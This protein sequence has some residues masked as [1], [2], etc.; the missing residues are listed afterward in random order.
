MP[1]E[2]PKGIIYEQGYRRYEGAYRGRGY[3][4]WSLWFADFKRALGIGK[5]WQYKTILGI[6]FAITFAITLFF[7]FM[8][9]IVGL[10]TSTPS[11]LTNP[12]SALFDGMSLILLI[13][14]AMVAPDLLC[15]DRKFKVLSLYLVR[16]IE[17]YDYLLAKAGAI[18]GVLLLA[19][20]VPQLGILLAKAFTARDAVQY[21]S[22]H[23]RDL[24]ALF[25]SSLIYAVFY[26]SFAMA[27]SSLTP[28]RAHAT[29]AI[30]TVPIVLGF[31]ALFLIASTK[32]SYWQLLDLDSLPSGLKNALFGVSYFAQDAR[33]TI[34]EQAVPLEPLA[35]W[36]YLVAL[37]AV[38]AFSLS[39]VL[40]SYA[41]ERP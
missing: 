36:I 16:P 18:F 1:S 31:I 22:E 25:V 15:S 2:V 35:W 34:N 40:F 11:A 8:D 9:F 23:T 14:S 10:G 39:I 33:V 12:H 32:S 17:L 19:S 4:I 27:A 30:I 24:G 28:Q 38:V 5:S 3:A 41:R 37:G 13:L 26:A 29:G 6:I 7:Y 21:I 20:L